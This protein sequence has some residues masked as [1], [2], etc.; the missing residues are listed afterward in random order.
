MTADDDTFNVP[1]VHAL[2]PD[3]LHRMKTEHG[4]DLFKLFD[5]LT[6]NYIVDDVT[7]API[8]VTFEEAVHWQHTHHYLHLGDDYFAHPFP[9]AEDQARLD[10][11]LHEI[12]AIPDDV[13]LDPRIR[14]S[15]VFLGNVTI[16][17]FGSTRPPRLW[18]TMIFNGPWSGHSEKYT[19]EDDALKGHA[20][21]CQLVKTAIKI[22]PTLLPLER[23]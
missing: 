17:P 20:V 22:Y 11:Q 16:N 4:R 8:K 13:H 9:P 10:A 1:V 6:E 23:P 5:E 12:A 7:G 15:T 3:F 14:V 2:G 21:Y 19:S 18:E